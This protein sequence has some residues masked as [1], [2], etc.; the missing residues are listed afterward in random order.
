MKKSKH[1]HSPVSNV[2]Y[3]PFS[4]LENIGNSS[5]SFLHLYLKSY[6]ISCHPSDK[7]VLCAKIYNSYYVPF[8]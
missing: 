6:S 1:D 5:Q 7:T 3:I 4:V 8:P 2:S